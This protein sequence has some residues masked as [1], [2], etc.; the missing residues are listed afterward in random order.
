MLATGKNLLRDFLSVLL[1]YDHTYAHYSYKHTFAY[2]QKLSQRPNSWTSLLFSHWR[3]LLPSPPSPPPS[4]SGLKLVKLVCNVS[5][6]YGNI[7]SENSQD[8][9]Q[10]PQQNCTL[11]NLSLVPERFS[12]FCFLHHQNIIVGYLENGQKIIFV[13]I[14]ADMNN[15]AS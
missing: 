4:K 14:W 8:Y 6:A 7:K 13:K 3:I 9:A 5:I 11:M 12:S 1:L 15:F 2:S 10:Q